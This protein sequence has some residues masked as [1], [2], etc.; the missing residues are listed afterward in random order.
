MSTRWPRSPSRPC[1]DGSV[2][3]SRTDLSECPKCGGPLRQDTDVLDTWFSSGLWPFSTLGWPESTPELKVFYPTS[4]L[5]TGFDILT[6]WVAR[7]AMLG[8]KF[9]GDVPFHHV[10]IHALV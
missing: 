3:V 4:V 7:M 10:Y 8:I 2:H 5:S 1:G 9:M 6:F